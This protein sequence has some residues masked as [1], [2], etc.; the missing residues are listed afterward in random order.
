[1][2]GD[3]LHLGKPFVALVLQQLAEMTGLD[4]PLVC[5]G[6]AGLTGGALF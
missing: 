3:T 1:M 2:E 5:V 4:E 6:G